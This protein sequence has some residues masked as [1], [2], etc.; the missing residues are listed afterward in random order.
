MAVFWRIIAGR[1]STL[2][3]RPKITQSVASVI[4][5]CISAL[6]YGATLVS[7]HEAA[8]TRRRASGS[9]SSGLTSEIASKHWWRTYVAYRM[10]RS[11]REDSL[12][13]AV[14]RLVG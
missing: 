9:L 13:V 11:G 12:L 5:P 2:S 14:K 8:D 3:R 7:L 1:F 6:F 4:L 10:T